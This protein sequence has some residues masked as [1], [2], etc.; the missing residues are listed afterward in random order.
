[1][2]NIIIWGIGNGFRRVSA[3]IDYLIEI[4]DIN[5]VAFTGNEKIKSID[6]V[7][8]V[9]KEELKTIEFDYIV[10]TAN[11]YSIIKDEAI[12]VYNIP[13]QRILDAKILFINGFRFESYRKLVDQNPTFISNN[14]T[15]GIIYN[16]L[17]LRFTSPIINMFIT[18]YD[19]I[20]FSQNVPKYISHEIV[21]DSTAYDSGT[22]IQ[23]PVYRIEDSRIKLHM[24]HYS[25]FCEG[26]RKWEE[27]KQRINFD[28]LI[29]VFSSLNATTIEK[30]ND[31]DFDKKIIFTNRSSE[32][33][34]E[35]IVKVN[36]EMDG[37]RPFWYYV[38]GSLTGRYPM[39]NVMELLLNQKVQM[40]IA[41]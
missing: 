36:Q 25:D 34:G 33:S 32:I 14:C 27:R 12:W 26:K 28:N 16:M 37:E 8:F 13:S 29:F 5:L 40:K 7:P 24:N 15:G 20:E 31:L 3:I 38:Q 23:Y 30:F 6:G 22:K 17:G 39:Y 21:L 10:V 1:M 19:F 35:S 18:D 11:T 41:T 9:R 4:K 2:Q